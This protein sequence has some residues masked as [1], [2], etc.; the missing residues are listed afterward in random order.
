MFETLDGRRQG[1]GQHLGVGRIGHNPCVHLNVLGVRIVLAK[2][3][4]ELKWVVSNLKV[5]RIFPFANP[6]F[7]CRRLHYVT[8]KAIALPTWIWER[9]RQSLGYVSRRRGGLISCVSLSSDRRHVKLA[10]C[11]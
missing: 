2:I 6:R 11:V 4:I 1:L 5:A 10:A 3:Y 7:F 8:C 9:F